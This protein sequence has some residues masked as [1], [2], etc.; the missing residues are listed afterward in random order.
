MPS[1][2][3][4][5]AALGTNVP[6]KTSKAYLIEL[7][8]K[9]DAPAKGYADKGSYVAFQYF[10][11]TVSD[12]KSIN[13]QTKEVPGGSLP[14]YQWISSGERLISF[15]AQFTCDVDL[16]G[17]GNVLATT[18][19]EAIAQESASQALQRRLKAA[20][21]S[22]RNPDIRAAIA[23][24]RRFVL[25]S[26]TDQLSRAPN[27]LKLFMP[28]S[29]LGLAG[30]A[31]GD[32]ANGS[33]D[34]IVSVMTQCEVTYEAFFPSGLIR[35]ATVQLAFAQIPQL[36]GGV[37]FPRDDDSMRNSAMDYTDTFPKE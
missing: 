28:G 37:Y 12:S 25:P 9:T 21:Q 8:K 10:P 27:K 14:L 22:R 2:T 31:M 35:T 1:L 5:S 34:S 16:S 24:L 6:S 23:W 4:L 13:Y 18:I 26:Y 30:G 3:S 11:E 20:G 19:A 7:D 36:A 32:I 15:S 17:G 33:R 29:G